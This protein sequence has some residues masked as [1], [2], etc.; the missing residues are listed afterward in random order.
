MRSA[1][2]GLDAGRPAKILPKPKGATCPLR[3]SL[4]PSNVDSSANNFVYAIATLAFSGNYPTGG[5]TID[6]T[7]LADKLPSTQI[8]Q[9]FA[10]SQNGNNGYYGVVAG[11]ALNNWK[12]KAFSGGGT[13]ISAGAYPASVTTDVVRLAIT[14]RRL[15]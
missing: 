3:F 9:A 5:D 10:E 6:F 7:T 14:A 2:M 12:L 13:E 11:A 1:V 8:I 4:S 15:L